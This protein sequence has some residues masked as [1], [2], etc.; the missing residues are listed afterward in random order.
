MP[1]SVLNF[2]Q[3]LCTIFNIIISLLSVLMC[4][5]SCIILLSISMG[6]IGVPSSF[7][8]WC[9]ITMLG[10]YSCQGTFVAYSYRKVF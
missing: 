1:L 9:K 3:I 7:V 2:L 5:M 4:F 6:F 10:S 8:P